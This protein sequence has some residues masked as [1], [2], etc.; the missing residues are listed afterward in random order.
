MLSEGTTKRELIPGCVKFNIPPEL[1]RVVGA[2]AVA[3]DVTWQNLPFCFIF[4][5]VENFR[6]NTY[7]EGEDFL[8]R[9]DDDEPL[10][11]FEIVRDQ[12]QYGTVC[13]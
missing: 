10:F 2:V 4:R 7:T 3:D 6:L 13:R 1:F 5:A 9:V 12:K 11:D 8:Y